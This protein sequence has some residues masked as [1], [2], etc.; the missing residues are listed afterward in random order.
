MTFLQLCQLAREKCEFGSAATP[1]TVVGQTGRLGQLVN[2]VNEAWVYIQLYR[3]DWHW[4]QYDF[5]FQ[6]IA[7]QSL[8]PMGTGAGQAGVLK[9]HLG[10]WLPDTGRIYLTATGRSDESFIPYIKFPDFRDTYDFGSTASLQ[11]RPVVWSDDERTQGIL[12]GPIPDAVYTFKGRY[13]HAPIEMTADGDEPE[14]P[15]MFHR[16]IVYKVMMLYGAADGAP[17]VYA[18]GKMQ[19]EKMMANLETHQTQSLSLGDPLA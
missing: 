16:L 3:P 13:Y 4:L 9:L 18:E 8:Y 5:T 2:W 7:G 15:A 17:E 1:T 19:F 14:M 12:L 6:T 11:Q 10:H